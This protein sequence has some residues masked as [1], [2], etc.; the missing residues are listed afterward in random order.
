MGCDF[1]W[2][3]AIPGESEQQAAL[4]LY[5]AVY[6]SLEDWTKVR[7]DRARKVTALFLDSIY[8]ELRIDRP[9]NRRVES[10]PCDFFGA[11]P[12]L[13]SRSGWDMWRRGQ[14]V[15]DRSNGGRIVSIAMAE[16]EDGYGPLNDHGVDVV[17]AD[18]AYTR[19]IDYTSC[20]ALALFLN[21]MKRRLCPELGCLDDRCYMDRV[22]RAIDAGG[23]GDEVVAPDLNAEE[24]SHRFL[25]AFLWRPNDPDQ[26]STPLDPMPGIG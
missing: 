16:L 11:A 5:S 22:S 19:L 2:W 17:V 15:F 7:P 20:S 18:G 25:T 3:G 14:I 9:E 23:F 13:D 24:F 12:F 4:N 10:Y 8:G 6:K 26:A 1:N 21:L